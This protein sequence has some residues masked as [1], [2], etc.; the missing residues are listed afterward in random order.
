MNSGDMALSEEF[1]VSITDLAKM[2][3][4]DVKIKL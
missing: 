3:N 1:V 2:L 4:R